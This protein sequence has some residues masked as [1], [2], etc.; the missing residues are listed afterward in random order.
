MSK[1]A[2]HSEEKPAKEDSS[3]SETEDQQEKKFRLAHI[4]GLKIAKS[5]FDD[6]LFD[7]VPELDGEKKTDIFEHQDVL[8]KK[9]EKHAIAG[10]PFD[11]VYQ[12]SLFIQKLFEE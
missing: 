9:G 10:H 5:L 12:A 6:E 8:S 7:L 4:K 2:E 1:S 3:L 11:D